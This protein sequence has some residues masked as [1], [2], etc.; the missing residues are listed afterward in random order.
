MEHVGIDVHKNQ[1]DRK[2]KRHFRAPRCE[3][4]PAEPPSASRPRPPLARGDCRAPSAPRQP[5]GAARSKAERGVARLW[6][7]LDRRLRMG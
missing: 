2:Y 3:C 5:A 6:L 1:A 4:I 7:V